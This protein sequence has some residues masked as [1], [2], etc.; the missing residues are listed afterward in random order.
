MKCYRRHFYSNFIAIIFLFSISK[1]DSPES[2]LFEILS[3]PKG[4]TLNEKTFNN[5]VTELERKGIVDDKLSDGFEFIGGPK[6]FHNY[7]K[8]N[9]ARLVIELGGELDL[10]EKQNSE[11]LETVTLSKSS[12]KN[13]FLFERFESIENEEQ[14]ILNRKHTDSKNYILGLNISKPIILSK[15]TES[16]DRN[17]SSAYGAYIVLPYSLK[18]ISRFTEKIAN[19]DKLTINLRPVFGL[20]N[21][22]FKKVL[23]DSIVEVLG[24][25]DYFFAGLYDNYI[26]NNLDIDIVILFGG[27]EDGNFGLFTVNNTQIPIN[28]F[29]NNLK[30]FIFSNASIIRQKNSKITGWIDIGLSIRLKIDLE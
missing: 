14:R 3:L 24:G 21:F 8:A 10:Q 4:S 28:F 23:N 13:K 1:S 30:F 25:S 29:K 9:A 19:F 26:F 22:Y 18:R 16:Y 27:D 12:T 7:I 2:I 20:K 15:T 5:F 6:G 17:S 11:T